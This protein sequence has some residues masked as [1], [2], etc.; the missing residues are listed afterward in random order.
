MAVTLAECSAEQLS[1]IEDG[2][3]FPE[4]CSID[5]SGLAVS[6][7]EKKAK[8]LVRNAVKRDWLFSAS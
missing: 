6:S 1:V 3:P 7:V 8:M 2:I 5:F 4:H